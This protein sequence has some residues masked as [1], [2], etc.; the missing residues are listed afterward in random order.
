[1]LYRWSFTNATDT[2]TNS[3]AT[4]AIA[5]GTGN[6]VLQNVSGNI[7]GST[8]A[9]AVNPLLYFTNASIGPQPGPSGV[10]SLV[11]NGQ[12][13]NGGNTAVATA[14]NLNLGSM[15]QFTLTFWFQMGATTFGQFPRFVLLSAEQ[16]YDSG[17]KGPT[18]NGVGASV[19]TAP[20]GFPCVQN[21]VGNASTSQNPIMSVTNVFPSG[22]PLDGS[23]WVFEA[24]TYDGTLNQSNFITWIGTA[25]QPIQ[26]V[27]GGAQNAPYGAINF[28][29]NASIMI[30]NDNIPALPRALNTGGIADVRIYAGTGNSNQLDVIRQFGFPPILANSSA[31]AIVNQ[32]Y[33]GTSFVNGTR[34]FS[35]TASGTPSPTYSWKSNGVPVVGATGATLAVSN[36]QLAASGSSFVC[37]IT[38]ALGGTNTIPAI[39]TVTPVSSG[40]DY[41]KYVV[42]QSPY[43]FWEVNEPS[44]GV[45]VPVFDYVG[46]HDGFA[47]NPVNMNFSF[48]G[49]T[50]PTFYGFPAVNSTIETIAGVGQ[51]RLNAGA[52]GNYPNSGM[53]IAGWVNTPGYGNTGYG[54]IYNEASDIGPFFGLTFG[55]PGSGG[56][57][58]SEVDYIWGT[59]TPTFT[60]GICMNTNEWT[61][62]ALVIST[63]AAPDTNATIYVGSETL[64]LSSTNDST[65]ASGDIIVSGSDPNILALGRATPT[66]SENNLF[67]YAGTTSQF[68]DVAVFY[69][70]LS[71]AAISNLFLNGVGLHLNGVKDPSTPGNLL[72]NWSYGYLQSASI[73]S[74][75]YADVP[76]TTNGVPYT[77]PI[78]GTK[79]YK[80][81][82]TP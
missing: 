19:N 76:L 25:S 30:G 27:T 5:P 31:P 7:F 61:F 9:D 24:I 17:G 50:N 3:A 42:S 58:G 69:R 40:G 39:L 71:P 67:P 43:S 56:G 57:N 68:S 52:P 13:Y 15:Y 60:S 47:V 49:P 65:A 29:T 70:A 64:G 21:G 55:A 77:T 38:N 82:A 4:Y 35:V 78:S 45:P 18:V 48:S 16:N 62:V 33:S 75:P 28:T 63:N 51:S 2:F 72:L 32:P 36:V 12:G 74:G 34:Y 44:N 53:T 10:A 1:M 22:L 8:G 79:F 6:L 26:L 41:A 73:V 54:L 80:V 23:T 37:S 46:G 59:T 20:T 11:A 81:S 14:T 66:G